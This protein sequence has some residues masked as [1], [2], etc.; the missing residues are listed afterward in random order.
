MLFDVDNTLINGFSVI[1]FASYLTRQGITSHDSWNQIRQ[2]LELPRTTQKQYA[3][4]TENVVGHFY[5]SLKGQS[6]KEIAVESRLYMVR[7]YMAHLKPYAWQLIDLMKRQGALIGVSGAPKEVFEPLAKEWGFSQ[8]YLLEGEVQN[9][10]YTGRVKT[11]MALQVAKQKA[12]QNILMQ[13][14]DIGQSFAFGDHPD[15]D[16]PILTA[17]SHPFFILGKDNVQEMEALAQQRGYTPTTEDEILGKVMERI[18]QLHLQ[19]VD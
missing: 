11:N 6:E 3:D 18:D 15:H 8:T 10:V 1:L 2:D 4:F 5:Q 14:F 13:G 17:V 12:V 7:E 19:A 9:G 16:A